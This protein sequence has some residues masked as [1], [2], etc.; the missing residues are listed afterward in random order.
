MTASLGGRYL[1]AH[2]SQYDLGNP[3]R[4]RHEGCVPAAVANGADASSGGAIDK[5]VAAVHNLIPQS[6]ETDP[7][8]PGWSL[9]DADRACVKLGIPFEI[10]TGR[11]WSAVVAALDSG[12]YVILQGDSDQFPNGTC[13]GDFDGDHAVGLHPAARLVGGLRQRWMDDGICPTGRWESEYIL[14]RYARKL[15]PEIRFGVFTRPVPRVSS[16]ATVLATARK[17]RYTTYA[18]VNGRARVAGHL[19]TGGFRAEARIVR[20]VQVD[21][22]GKTTLLELTTGSHAGSILWA[23]APGITM[24]SI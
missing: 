13:S 8:K 19:T 3:P 12:L 23:R 5:S 21:G 6:Q 15:L 1:N 24:R 22:T 20:A 14:H 10:R 7:K 11:G 2:R 4:T 18:V 17:G 9:T 16:G